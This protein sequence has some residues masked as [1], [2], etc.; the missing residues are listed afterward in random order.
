[1]T[2]GALEKAAKR[3]HEEEAFRT[4][5]PSFPKLRLPRRQNAEVV[6]A[7]PPMRTIRSAID[8]ATGVS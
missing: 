3:P 4:T 2:G 5:P 7:P 1:M 8:A 6:F